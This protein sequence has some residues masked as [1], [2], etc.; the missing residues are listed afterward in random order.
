MLAPAGTR[1]DGDRSVELRAHDVS[2]PLPPGENLKVPYVSV[3]DGLQ[4]KAIWRKEAAGHDGAHPAARGYRLFADAVL[5][6]GWTDWLSK[7][8]E[9]KP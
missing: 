1:F 7:P 3:M 2:E 5:A 4:V 9:V 8:S 6:A